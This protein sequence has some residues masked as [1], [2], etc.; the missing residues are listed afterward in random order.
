MN[1]GKASTSTLC[2]MQLF[3]ELAQTRVAIT[4]GM[5]TFA[6]PKIIQLDAAFCSTIADNLYHVGHDVHL[7]RLVLVIPTVIV[8][9]DQTLFQRLIW[10]VVHHYRMFIFLGL[11]DVL[12]DHHVLQVFQCSP[13][14]Q[15]NRATK[16]LCLGEIIRVTILALRIEHKINLRSRE[17]SLWVIREHH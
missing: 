10:I 6:S 12:P 1:G 11:M 8:G 13:Q 17:E 16:R 9:I 4:T 15:M 14:C 5:N 3:K 7:H 2:Q